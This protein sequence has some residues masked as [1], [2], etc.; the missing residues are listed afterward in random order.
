MLKMI[1]PNCSKNY[2]S[3]DVICFNCG[4]LLK[5]YS[6]IKL[7]KLDYTLPIEDLFQQA[8]D[9]FIDT[10]NQIS[11]CN[12]DSDK[13]LNRILAYLPNTD[14]FL[15]SDE[16]FFSLKRVYVDLNQVIKELLNSVTPLFIDLLVLFN[17][18]SDLELNEI[19]YNLL[20]TSITNVYD[21]NKNFIN[22]DIKPAKNQFIN[23][24]PYD[25][26]QDCLKAKNEL[27]SQ[28]NKFII[29]YDAI[30]RELDTIK[31]KF[32]NFENI[33]DLLNEVQTQENEYKNTL[34]EKIKEL[35]EK[36]QYEEAIEYYDH[37]IEMFPE[38]KHYIQNKRN[39]LPL[40]EIYNENEVSGETVNKAKKN[41]LATTNK[42][43]K[44]PRKFNK[45]HTKNRKTPQ[46]KKSKPQD[47][48]GLG[49]KIYAI[50]GSI[51][52]IILIISIILTIMGLMPI[53]F[54]ILFFIYAII[55]MIIGKILGAKR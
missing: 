27:I 17:F 37:L 36:G 55:Y 18:F 28:F 45:K 11:D 38:E 15:D 3:N 34:K 35:E 14:V 47:E 1:C 16:Y 6:Q 54:W 46:N 9:L 42:K 2:R 5:D 48:Y 29:F 24:M 12:E 8:I 39:I 52:P 43:T 22:S 13:K 30:A 10:L 31:Q 49:I 44:T 50:L 23:L 41:K 53:T 26:P 4:F 32:M 25:A 19:T 51:T 20:I 40:K 21:T 33:H 7:D